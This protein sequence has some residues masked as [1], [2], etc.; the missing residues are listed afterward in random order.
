MVILFILECRSQTLEEWRGNCMKIR[1]YAKS[2]G[3]DVVGKLRY[4]G[5][6]NRRTKYFVDDGGNAYL[7]DDFTKEIGII[8]YQN[9]IIL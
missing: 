2:V 6:W 5:K 4:M 8:P 3:F 9:K 1:K 7:I